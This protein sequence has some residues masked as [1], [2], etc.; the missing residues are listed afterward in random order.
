MATLLTHIDLPEGTEA[1]V[2]GS[3]KDRW[4]AHDI[5]LLVVYDP[6]HI[7]PMNAHAALRPHIDAIKRKLATPVHMVLLTTDEESDAH[8]IESQG[9]IP[10]TSLSERYR[11]DLTA[12]SM[13]FRS[14]SLRAIATVVIA[15]T[16]PDADGAIKKRSDDYKGWRTSSCVW[17][18]MADQ[19]NF[20]TARFRP[21]LPNFS[22]RA[23]SAMS[24][25]MR[26]ARSR[27]N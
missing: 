2:F 13:N 12:S 23:G 16:L 7:Y 21:A 6:K 9:C 27:A 20:S 3:A 26:A 1:Y 24:W 25:L 19:L 11:P 14:S 4:P 5:D 18:A 10:T 17:A 15:F 22:R 8:Y